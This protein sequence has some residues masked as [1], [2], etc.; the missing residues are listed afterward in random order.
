MRE[1][2]CAKLLASN[3]MFRS[4][5]RRQ[6]RHSCLPSPRLVCYDVLCGHS[7]RPVLLRAS[8]CRLFEQ[9]VIPGR[10]LSPKV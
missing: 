1:A 9:D 2:W 8:V 6:G 5:W 7:V 4:D 10:F 3:K